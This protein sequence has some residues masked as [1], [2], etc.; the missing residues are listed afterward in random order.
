MTDERFSRQRDLVPPERLKACRATVVGV[1]AIGRQVALQLTA[2]G[3]PWLQL[4]DFDMVEESNLASQGYLECDL[5]IQKVASTSVLCR[6]ISS[7][8]DLYMVADR[9]R[10]TMEVGNVLFSC[11][12]KIDIR[13]DAKLVGDI[14]TGRIMI[15]DGAYFKGSIDIVREVSKPAPAPSPRPPA[16]AHAPSAAPAP[17]AAGGIDQKH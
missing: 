7:R 5:G 10:R 11:V 17:V 1:G 2:M 12:D 8:V 3:A 13:K 15:E 16:V 4:V 14:K 9:F 6:R